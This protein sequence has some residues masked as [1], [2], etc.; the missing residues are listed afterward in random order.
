MD[1]KDVPD[2]YSYTDYASTT[3]WIYPAMVFP[4]I[5]KST[6]AKTVTMR[7]GRNFAGPTIIYLGRPVV[8]PGAC[9]WLVGQ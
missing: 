4:V 7:L 8:R 1:L 3:Q 2:G 9:S 5:C 6:T